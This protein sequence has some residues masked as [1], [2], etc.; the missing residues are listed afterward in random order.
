M[1]NELKV[2]GYIAMLNTVLRVHDHAPELNIPV[3]LG[4]LS[5]APMPGMLKR[6]K[7]GRMCARAL[8]TTAFSAYTH[9]TLARLRNFAGKTVRSFSR[10]V[11]VIRVSSSA[12]WQHFAPLNSACCA[13]VATRAALD[14]H[15]R[16]A[17]WLSGQ[18]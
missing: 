9:R 17:H 14:L 8:S 4:C 12:R 2:L 16:D 6:R 3:V 5:P 1:E 13:N 11:K 15:G 10:L 7:E 18:V